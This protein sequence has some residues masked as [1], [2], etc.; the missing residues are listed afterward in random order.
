MQNKITKMKAFLFLA[1]V[2]FLAVFIS[3]GLEALTVGDQITNVNLKD[4]NDDPATIPDIGKKVLIIFYTDPD[5]SEA[6]EPVR[7][8]LK[9]KGLDKSKYRGVGV[10][11]MKDTW[12]PNAIIRTVARSK[13]KKFKSLILTDPGYL[14]KDAWK[15]GDCDDKDIAIL[16]GKDKKVKYIS[17]GKIR[18][19]EIQKVVALVESE[20]AK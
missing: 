12:K 14:L 16:V 20:M 15:L 1:G 2:L 18:G 10:V 3:A 6:N 9:A 7:D 5:V 19:E 8:A 11:N 17:Y 4:S 13:E